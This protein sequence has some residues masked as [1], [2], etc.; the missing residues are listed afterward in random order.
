MYL[1]NEWALHNNRAAIFKCLDGPLQFC[2]T[3]PASPAIILLEV[4]ALKPPSTAT[5]VWVLL[6][7][8]E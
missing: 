4:W 2:G 7:E 1:R 5:A 8:S 6:Q 3:D